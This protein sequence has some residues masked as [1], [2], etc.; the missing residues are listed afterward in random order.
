MPRVPIVSREQLKP[1]DRSYFDEISESRGGIRGPYGILLYSPEL[2]SRIAATG[3]YVRFEGNFP[4]A[5]REVVILTTAKE[6]QSQYQFTSH[7]GL[8][9]E[10]K[11]SEDTIRAI[12]QGAAPQ[13]LS[14]DEELVVRYVQELLRHRKISD[15]TFNAVMARF[16][17][18]L[19]VDLTVL[20][21]HY[22]M[23]GAVL[24]AFEI[25]PAPGVNPEL[26]L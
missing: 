18:Q 12:A 13:G 11:V 16:G 17:V 20:I 1:E 8:A 26:P 24:A 9:R 4:N 15:D 25:E 22:L 23:A 21:G 2:A 19:T 6:I 10:A 14:G 7:A 3:A 5:L